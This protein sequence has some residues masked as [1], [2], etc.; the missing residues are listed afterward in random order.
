MPH[1]VTNKPNV[2]KSPRANRQDF[3]ENLGRYTDTHD[4]ESPWINVLLGGGQGAGK[5]R[6]A[7]TAPGAS[8]PNG[9]LVLNFDEGLRTAYSM[10]LNPWTFDASELDH[11]VFVKTRALA[12]AI[13]DGDERFAKLKTVVLDAYTGMSQMF[14]NAMLRKIGRDPVG[15]GQKA[16]Y[17]QWAAVRQQMRTI[18]NLLKQAPVN[19]IAI[20]HTDY[21]DDKQGNLVPTYDIDGSFRK[22]VPKLFDEV[23]Y[24]EPYVNGPK[25]E[26]RT[27]IKTHP[28]GWP[29]KSRTF[30]EQSDLP[31][32]KPYVVN[33]DWNM[34]FNELWTKAKQ[35]HKEGSKGK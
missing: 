30:L 22:D 17:D 7:M 13:I 35:T 28:K 1:E 3:T 19:L 9:M 34:L 16:E 32:E 6:F 4:P 15:P 8:E 24:M 12:Q 23:Y 25:T 10:G 31:G 29:T 27:Y 14:M 5:T 2:T 33:A 20:A 11:D 26:Y 21:R 18:T